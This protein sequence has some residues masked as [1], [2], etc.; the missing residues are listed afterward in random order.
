MSGQRATTL[1]AF[2][3]RAAPLP[4]APGQAQRGAPVGG[5]GDSDL[6]RRQADRDPQ[7]SSARASLPQLWEREVSDGEEQASV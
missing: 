4:L 2:R 1:L 5:S 3:W 6:R 7:R